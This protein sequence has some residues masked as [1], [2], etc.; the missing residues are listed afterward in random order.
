MVAK[1]T[2]K[3]LIASFWEN[4]GT[5]VQK[6]QDA[7]SMEDLDTLMGK[8]PRELMLSHVHKL[9]QVCV[10]VSY[11]YFFFSHL[12]VVASVGRVLLHLWKVLGL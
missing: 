3:A 4:I 9:I 11:A 8:S 10:L 5:S 1:A 7:I 12:F 6:D 2:S